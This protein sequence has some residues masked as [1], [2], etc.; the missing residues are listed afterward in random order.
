MNFLN[1]VS[2]MWN[3]LKLILNNPKILQAFGYI[4]KRFF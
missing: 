1:T 2:Q 4:L 3:F